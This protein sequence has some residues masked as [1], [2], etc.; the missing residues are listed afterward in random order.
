MSAVDDR[1]FRVLTMSVVCA[2]YGLTVKEYWKLS[3]IRHAEMVA[4]LFTAL[5]AAVPTP[6]QPEGEPEE[7]N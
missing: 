5:A 1:A 3:A 2:V 6:E 7:E 4:G